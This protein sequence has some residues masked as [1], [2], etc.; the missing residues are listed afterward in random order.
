[1]L[2]NIQFRFIGVVRTLYFVPAVV[3]F[4]ASAILWQWI[5]RPGQGILDFLLQKVGINGPAW[6]EQHAHRPDLPGH[7]LDLAVPA[8]RDLA[9]PGRPAADT[10]AGHRGGHAGR[11]RTCQPSAEHHLAGRAE[12]DDP[13]RDRHHPGLHQ[14]LIRPVNILTQGGPINVTT[15][16]IYYIYYAAFNNLQL[17]YAAALSVLQLALSR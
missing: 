3:S 4:A 12:H 10:P 7:H 14:Q 6:L 8:H 2:V 13:G 1:M 9:V 5:Y 17:G 11:R 15:T 16:L